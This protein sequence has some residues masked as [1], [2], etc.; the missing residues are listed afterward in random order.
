MNTPYRYF[1]IRESDHADAF[2]W[3]DLL[4]KTEENA[5]S[6]KK[7]SPPGSGLAIAGIIWVWGAMAF[8]GPAYFSVGPGAGKTIFNIFGIIL[9][10]VSCVG[11]LMEF[12][13]L[14]RNEAL[15]Y[16]SVGLLF[17]IPALAIHFGASSNSLTPS[18]LERVLKVIAYPLCL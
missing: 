3:R 8:L 9:I 5:T 11:A 1:Q 18:T 2:P 17:L 12:S 14:W 13:K 4:M 16:W 6:S 15:S 7:P 10:T